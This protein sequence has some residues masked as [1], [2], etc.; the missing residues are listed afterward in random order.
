MKLKN[1]II[2]FYINRLSH[3]AGVNIRLDG[4][5]GENGKRNFVTKYC[6]AFE[7]SCPAGA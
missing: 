2:Q 4:E 3:Y 6:R 5:I 7:L 1:D